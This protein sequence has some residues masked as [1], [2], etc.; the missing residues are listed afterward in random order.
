MRSYK[1]TIGGA[2]SAFG[3]SLM[4][5]GAYSTIAALS[6]DTPQPLPQFVLWLW[7]TGFILDGLG[8]FFA[9][10]FAA[11]RSD[12]RRLIRQSENDTKI[13]LRGK[14]DVEDD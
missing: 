2:C 14:Q 7:V 13:M 8:G 4:G 9:H 1:S 12:V 6:S 5:I 11:D 10:L 3:K